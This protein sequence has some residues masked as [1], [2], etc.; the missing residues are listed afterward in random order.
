MTELDDVYGRVIAELDVV[1]E[2]PDVDLWNAVHR[3]GSCGWLFTSGAAPE[4]TGN[5]RV[6]RAAV[7]PICGAC[8]VW[9]EC[10]ELE[11]RTHGDATAGVWGPLDE[12]GRRGAFLSWLDRRD[13]PPAGGRR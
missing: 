4:W 10:L 2:L 6:D 9:R 11:F 5:D 13:S 7:A 3:R 8:P 1:A 12:E